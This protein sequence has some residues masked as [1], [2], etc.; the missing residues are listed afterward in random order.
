[1]LYAKYPQTWKDENIIIPAKSPHTGRCEIEG[2][3]DVSMFVAQ[4]CGL[5]WLSE[6]FQK[7]THGEQQIRRN[8]FKSVWKGVKHRWHLFRNVVEIVWD[9]AATVIEIVWDI[10]DTLLSHVW[11][12][13]WDDSEWF[14][15]CLK[16]EKKRWVTCLGHV[17]NG[18]RSCLKQFVTRV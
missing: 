5:G 3:P 14:D 8:I 13:F 12:C 7:V 10:F 15:N 17:W 4:A 1:M 2:G 9:V 6:P 18:F 16:K 11:N